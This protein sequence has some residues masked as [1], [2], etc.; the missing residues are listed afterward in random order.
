MAR[1]KP[2]I[3]GKTGGQ[4]SEPGFQGLIPRYFTRRRPRISVN[5]IPP[6]RAL[7]HK[8]SLK[9]V[10]TWLAAQDKFFKS[11]WR[12]REFTIA[13]FYFFCGVMMT[14]LFV[15][16]VLWVQ[17]QPQFKNKS[18]RQIISIIA[19]RAWAWDQ[20]AAATNALH[21]AKKTLKKLKQELP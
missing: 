13:W 9:K 19:H 11:R 7:Y 12:W 4:K 5:P 10:G 16:F 3:F 18:T 17:N 8:P 15:I 20:S 1:K 21:N 6:Y 2:N 14:G